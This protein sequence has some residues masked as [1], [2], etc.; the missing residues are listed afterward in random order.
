M[1]K[2]CIKG[3]KVKN[4]HYFMEVI[5]LQIEVS[6]FYYLVIRSL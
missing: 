5:G 6:I 4:N 2:S 1:G 3:K